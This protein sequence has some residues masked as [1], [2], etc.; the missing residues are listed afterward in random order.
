MS[1]SRGIFEGFGGLKSVVK[2]A[3]GG[4][5][6]NHEISFRDSGTATVEDAPA[7]TEVSLVTNVTDL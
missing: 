2:A 3:W 4:K 6:A 7:K 1:P 5:V